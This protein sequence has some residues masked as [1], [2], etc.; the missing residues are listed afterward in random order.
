[1]Q[2]WPV[3]AVIASIGLVVF[4]EFALDKFNISDFMCYTLMM[5]AL[6]VMSFAEIY[7]MKRRC[8]RRA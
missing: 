1:M 6:A 4:V 7:S 3:A 2:Y 8:A 5:V